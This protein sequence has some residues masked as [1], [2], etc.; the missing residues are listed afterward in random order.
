[1]EC[2][3]ISTHPMSII[4]I[5]QAWAWLATMELSRLQP[6]NAKHSLLTPRRLVMKKSLMVWT[7][8]F[9]PM[10]NFWAHVLLMKSA[11][12]KIT[13]KPRLGSCK[14]SAT[15]SSKKEMPTLRAVAPINSAPTRT[16]TW[17]RSYSSM[18]IRQWNPSRARLR[19][20]R[21][22]LKQTASGWTRTSSRPKKASTRA[23][24][25]RM[26]RKNKI[27]MSC[28]TMPTK[29]PVLKVQVAAKMTRQ[30]KSSQKILWSSLLSERQLLVKAIR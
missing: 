28:L 22:R 17:S 20:I 18:V 8:T 6:K 29:S 2:Q 30:N 9:S 5:Q 14:T 15:N 7:S 11:S 1:M 4:E 23:A 25:Q 16:M 3:N 10:R 24:L 12:A 13:R 27:A 26:P 19:R 21:G